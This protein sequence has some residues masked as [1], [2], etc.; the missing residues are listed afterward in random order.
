MANFLNSYN[1]A[2]GRYNQYLNFTHFDTEFQAFEAGSMVKGYSM[3]KT[4]PKG[5]PQLENY[6]YK[7]YPNAEDLVFP[8]SVYPQ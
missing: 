7:A 6:I 8:P 1:P 5:Y 2:T 4:G 3:F